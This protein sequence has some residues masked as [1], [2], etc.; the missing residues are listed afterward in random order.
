MGH[1]GGGSLTCQM[2]ESNYWAI[3]PLEVFGATGIWEQR[4]LLK[5]PHD[6]TAQCSTN[7][8]RNA[9]QPASRSHLDEIRMSD[10]STRRGTPEGASVS[11]YARCTVLGICMLSNRNSSCSGRSSPVLRS[12]SAQSA[13]KCP[14]AAGHCDMSILSTTCGRD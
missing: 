4:Q 5:I 3:Y 6:K 12:D 10:L 7:N 14:M 9:T 13:E 8:P 11:P 2:S 1:L